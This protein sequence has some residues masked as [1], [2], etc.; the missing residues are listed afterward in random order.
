LAKSLTENEQ[1][2][3][4]EMNS[5]QGQRVDIGGYFLADPVKTKQVMRPSDTFN[6]ALASL[7][8]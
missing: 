1:K 7:G 8:N 6:N 5:A 2:I 4:D 3:V